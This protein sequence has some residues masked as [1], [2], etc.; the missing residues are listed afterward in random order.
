MEAS[1][2]VGFAAMAG[3]ISMAIAAGMYSIFRHR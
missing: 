1:Q 3:A 2:M